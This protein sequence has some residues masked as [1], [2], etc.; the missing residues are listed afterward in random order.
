MLKKLDGL[1]DKRCLF[2]FIATIIIFIAS[3]K[4]CQIRKEYP[5]SEQWK[6]LSCSA[7]IND[8]DNNSTV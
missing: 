2:F 4:L 3:T 7:I 6:S 8:V 5:R 1:I